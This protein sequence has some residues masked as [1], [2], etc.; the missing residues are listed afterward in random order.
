MVALYSTL[1]AEGFQEEAARLKEIADTSNETSERA[2]AHLSLALLYSHYR[3]PSP[4]YQ[5][6]L[7]ELALY[8]SLDPEGSKSDT[9]R[10]WTA[11]LRQIVG[12][13][14]ETKSLKE[15][16]KQ[17]NNLENENKDLKEKMEQ[18]KNLE[19][20]YRSLKEKVEQL[21]NLDKENKEL[22]EKVEQLK[23][24][25]IELEKRRKIIK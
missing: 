23:E 9:I 19:N 17:S 6:A 4:H 8:E 10:N 25:D 24:L 18:C 13:E 21:K 11:V 22:K 16:A 20:E 2:R 7:N 12:L 5:A 15:T 1:T 14:R 3:N